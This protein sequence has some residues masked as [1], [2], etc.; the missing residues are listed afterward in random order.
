MKTINKILDVVFDSTLYLLTLLCF[1]SA[2]Y[3]IVLTALTGISQLIEATG[4]AALGVALS[5]YLMW[6]KS[7]SAGG[8]E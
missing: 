1:T 6:L 5:Y 4:I 8:G 7:K 2:G 3:L